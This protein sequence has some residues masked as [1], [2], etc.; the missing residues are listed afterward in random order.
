MWHGPVTTGNNSLHKFRRTGKH[1]EKK[2]KGR[3]SYTRASVDTE[4]IKRRWRKV[5]Q[6]GG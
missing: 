5:E 4:D 2:I 3:D 6:D 1:L